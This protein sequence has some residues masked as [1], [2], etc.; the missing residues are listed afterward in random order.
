MVLSRLLPECSETQFEMIARIEICA[1]QVVL[2]LSGADFAEA[3]APGK[4]CRPQQQRS[5]RRQDHWHRR[6]CAR[7]AAKDNDPRQVAVVSVGQGEPPIPR[8]RA[9]RIV[10]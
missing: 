8:A 3:P 4:I 5:S 6:C 2:F 9:E 7:Q 1:R 10:G